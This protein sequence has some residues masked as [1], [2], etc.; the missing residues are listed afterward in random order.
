LRHLSRFHLPCLLPVV[1]ILGFGMGLFGA[2]SSGSRLSELK[3]RIE[4][5]DRNHP[6][7]AIRAGEEAMASLTGMDT[8]DQLWF[9][10]AL[11]RDYLAA[12]DFTRVLDLGQRGLGIANAVGDDASLV[13]FRILRSKAQS[14]L[15]QYT[16]A[17]SE[18]ELALPAGNRLAA[19]SDRESHLTVAKLYKTFGSSYYQIARLGDALESFTRA[20][21]IYDQFGDVRG[22]AECLDAMASTHSDAG[23]YEEAV[24]CARKAIALAESLKNGSLMA[25]LH[26]TMAYVLVGHGDVEAQRQ[27]LFLARTQALACGD[28]STAL[29]STVNLS[30]SLLNA[31]AYVEAI[32]AVDEALP[33][34]RE[35]GDTFSE[36]VCWVN[37]GIALDHTG[38]SQEGLKLIQQGLDHF[39]KV[40]SAAYVV[41]ITGVLAEEYAFLGDFQKAYEFSRSFSELKDK[42]HKTQG[43]KLMAEARAS[44]ESDRKQLQIDVLERERR[45]QY[46]TRNLWIVIGIIALASTFALVLAYRRLHGVKVALDTLSLHDPLTGLANRRYLMGRIREDLAQVDRMHVSTPFQSLDSAQVRLNLDAILLML[47][48]DHFKSVNDHYGHGAGDLVIR[49]FANLVLEEVRDTD[50]VVRWG[51]EEFFILARHACREDGRLLAER[52]RR[53]VAEHVFDLGN[54]R[55]LH[56]TCSIGYVF[57]PFL[58]GTPLEVPWERMATVADQCL[59]AAKHSGRDMWIGVQAIDLDASVW[60]HRLSEDFQVETWV[61]EGWVRCE[62]PED[63]DIRWR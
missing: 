8:K 6:Q 41:E 17:K 11:A 51:G 12:K 49:Q 13:R 3:Q 59:Y 47:D 21:R 29:I 15:E 58:R 7:D 30:D 1:L 61:Q 38:H 50:T 35:I 4:K 9:L 63:R 27:E 33:L 2:A 32:Q 53:R 22:Q 48:M 45:G 34:A 10:E 57:Y 14:E 60:G 44:Y 23:Q 5:A 20:L 31:K 24:A 43:Q 40:K 36:A 42:L 62:H 37:K 26:A 54:G 39:K 56:K 18:L 46:R 28:V 16:K 25:K 19:S 55:T 52:I